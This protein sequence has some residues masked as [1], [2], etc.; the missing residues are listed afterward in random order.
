VNRR[1]G[2]M[3]VVTAAPPFA[4]CGATAGGGRGGGGDLRGGCGARGGGVVG[5]GARGGARGRGRAP[6]GGGGRRGGRRPPGVPPRPGGARGRR[7]QGDRRCR[8]ARPG[9]TLVATG[10]EVRE[11]TAAVVHRDRGRSSH[12]GLAG[13]GRQ[14]FA[15]RFAKERARPAGMT[16]AAETPQV[17]A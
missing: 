11:R 3:A 4:A 5:G 14:H 12:R 8:H 10:D 1:S 13:H 2:G 16:L 15:A 7:G 17:T 9:G 6:V